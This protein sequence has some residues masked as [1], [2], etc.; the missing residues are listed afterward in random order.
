MILKLSNHNINNLRLLYTD[1]TVVVGQYSLIFPDPYEKRYQLVA[2][3]P[4]E[5]YDPELKVH[6]VALL[7]VFVV[8]LL[9]NNFII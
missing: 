1:V 8:V 6:N 5:T 4:Y 9:Y 7:E 3:T 2:I